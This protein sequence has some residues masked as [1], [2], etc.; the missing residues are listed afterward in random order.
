[1]LGRQLSVQFARVT[2]VY[3]RALA[4]QAAL[5]WFEDQLDFLELDPAD[6]VDWVLQYEEVKDRVEDQVEEKED[7]DEDDSN[8]IRVRHYSMAIMNIKSSR[9]I[10]R[11]GTLEIYAE[12]PIT[13]PRTHEAM[14]AQYKH[15]RPGG[16]SLT[17][18]VEFNVDLSRWNVSPDPSF[19]GENAIFISRQAD[20]KYPFRGV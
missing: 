11:H 9:K 20:A 12:F 17:G 3:L 2:F 19:P 7:T 15:F 8:S 4:G 5:D 18:I 16:A 14:V 13:T 6:L 1:L 10:G